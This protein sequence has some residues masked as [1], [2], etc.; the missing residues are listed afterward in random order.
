MKYLQTMCF[1]TTVI[2]GVGTNVVARCTNSRKAA[3]D[4]KLTDQPQVGH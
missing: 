1:E 3:S 2:L 4:L